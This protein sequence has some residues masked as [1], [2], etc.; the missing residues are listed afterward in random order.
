MENVETAIDNEFSGQGSSSQNVFAED[1]F[2]HAKVHYFEKDATPKSTKQLDKEPANDTGDN[3]V[4]GVDSQSNE[5]SDSE[6]NETQTEQQF[7][8][9]SFKGSVLGKQVETKIESQAQLDKIISRGLASETI[10][11]KWQDS[12][13]KIQELQAMAESGQAFEGM[14]TEN[15]EALVDLIFEKYLDDVRAGKKILEM[16]EK[17]REYAKLS[18]EE[19]E[20]QKKL[21]LADQLIQEREE[22]EKIKQQNSEK[23]KQLKLAQQK[24]DDRNWANA[25]LRKYT[26]KFSNIEQELIKQQILN[27]MARVQLTRQQGTPMT[28]LQATQLLQQYLKPF[29]KL[30]SPSKLKD[31]AGKA[32]DQKISNSA[33]SLQNAARGQMRQKTQTESKPGYLDQA[34]VFDEI[35]NRILSGKVKLRP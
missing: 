25:E 34:D 16:F 5:T 28:H 6:S 11:K 35:K 26:A 15:P 22:A 13:N 18:P 27:V 31:D 3:S 17:Y 19:R 20:R 32:S 12:K 29:E 8:P 33:Q 14:A 2:D 9:Y 4:E 21:K 24:V 23:E 1:I 30:A 7:S 10:Y